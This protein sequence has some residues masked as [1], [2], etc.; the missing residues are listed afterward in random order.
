MDHRGLVIFKPWKYIRRTMG[1]CRAWLGRILGMGCGGECII[2]AMADSNSLPSLRHDSRTKKYV[3]NM[4]Y[5]LNYC[6]LCFNI[7]WNIPRA[8]W[9]SNICPCFRKL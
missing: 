3:K 8:Q 9:C 4:E 2:Y 7:V 1:L 6:L 5:K